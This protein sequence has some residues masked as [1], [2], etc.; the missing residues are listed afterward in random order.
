MEIIC[1]NA[2][3]ESLLGDN[4]REAA[5][6]L[7]FDLIRLYTSILTYLVKANS[8]YKQSRLSKLILHKFG[9]LLTSSEN[10]LKNGL[11]AS[12]DFE[13]AFEFIEGAQAYV[14]RSVTVLEL[15]GNSEVA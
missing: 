15:Q 14:D 3:V 8:Y 1:R 10:F 7:R 9:W 2:V 4:Q 13:S 6:R 5:E 12:S 11:L